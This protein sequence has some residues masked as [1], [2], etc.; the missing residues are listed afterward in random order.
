ML[1]HIVLKTNPSSIAKVKSKLL[2]TQTPPTF[3]RIFICFEGYIASFVGG[4]RLFI[5]FDG[6]HFK[7]PFR[8]ILSSAIGLDAKLQFF[9]ITIAIVRSENKEN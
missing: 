9:P 7:G 8:D 2:H 3:K 6:Y 1:P 4:Y 5:G